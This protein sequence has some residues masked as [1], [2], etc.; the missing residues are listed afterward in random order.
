M[1]TLATIS[2]DT[3]AANAAIKSGELQ[4]TL[5]STLERLKPEAAYFGTKDGKRTA[6]IVFDLK[7]PADIPP[8]AEPWFMATEASVTFQPIMNGDDLRAGLEAFA[9]G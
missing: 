8:I 2:L 9:R 5:G 6:F 4:K 7:S 1:R 3:A